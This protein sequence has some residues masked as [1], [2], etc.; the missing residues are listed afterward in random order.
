MGAPADA[1]QCRSERGLPQWKRLAQ[2]FNGKFIAN[3]DSFK[4]THVIANGKR[5]WIGN[6][7]NWKVFEGCRA[8][9]TE[10]IQCMS[11]NEV[12]T[13]P[14]GGPIGDINQCRSLRG[15]APLPPPPPPPPTVAQKFEGQ[16]IANCDAW[17]HT[18]LVANG[19][20]HWISN[21]DNW[22]TFNNCKKAA[23]EDVQCMSLADGIGARRRGHRP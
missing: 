16:F 1:N 18:H 2:K 17:K 14:D 5:H 13:V 3:C 19:K 9:P 23:N 10:D 21:K 4:N 12:N 8:A 22:N 6:K 11:L 20:R 7:D 15:L